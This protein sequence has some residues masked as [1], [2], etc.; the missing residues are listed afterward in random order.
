MNDCFIQIETN[1]AKRE[2]YRKNQITQAV[3]TNKVWIEFFD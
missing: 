2:N 3:M 1:I